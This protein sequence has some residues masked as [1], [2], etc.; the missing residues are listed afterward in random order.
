MIENKRF[1]MIDYYESDGECIYYDNGEE[2][3]SLDVVEKLNDLQEERD[4]FERKKCEYQ[5]KISI[6]TTDKITLKSVLEDTETLME[7]V[8]EQ[9]KL[10]DLKMKPET[11]QLL[12]RLENKIYYYKKV[13]ER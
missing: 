5:K 8:K 11:V 6:L 13:H 2:M 12:T 1:T 7:L 10:I 3:G 4:Y 9:N